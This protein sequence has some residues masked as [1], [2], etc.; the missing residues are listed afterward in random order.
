MPVGIVGSGQLAGMLAEAAQKMG[1][2]LHLQA[3]DPDDAAVALAAAAVFGP[4]ENGDAT[5]QLAKQCRRIGFENEWVDLEAI[6]ALE[7][8][9]VEFQP[10]AEVL[11]QVVDKRQQRNLLERLN[12]PSPGWCDLATVV[13]AGGKLPAQFEFPLMAKAA[14]GGY[15]GRGTEKLLNR[16]AFE[17]LLMRVDCREWILE[18]LVNYEKEL[19]ILVARNSAGEI[20]VFPLVETHQH[21]HQ[22]EWVLA[23][24]HVNHGVEARARSMA[25][26]IVTAINYVGLLAVEFFLSP[27]GLLINEL[28]PR[29]HNSGHYTIEACVTSQFCQQLNVLSNQR[30]GSTAL[31]VPGALMVNLVGFEESNNTYQEQRN[32][33]QAL[34][35]AH[36]HWYGKRLTRRG[37]KLGHITL[38]LQACD[39]V[40]RRREALEL[41]ARVRSIWPNP[42]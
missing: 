42:A 23:P 20:S 18:E 21:Q 32:L 3:S 14:A 2:E 5:T 25:V 22:C 19:S 35:Q 26:S 24:A 40:L 6:Q 41:L 11:T 39:P 38:L 28:A 16:A 13:S 15:D 4:S 10:C 12:L 36:L 37:R 29:S 30:L 8:E 7:V 31:L 17:A 1:L 34:P 9:G 27:Q 33:L